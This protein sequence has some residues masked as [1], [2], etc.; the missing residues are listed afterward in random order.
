M[1]SKDNLLFRSEALEAKQDRLHGQI[2]LKQTTSSVL[3]SVVIVSIII[4]AVIWITWGEYARTEQVLGILDTTQPSSKIMAQRSGIITELNVSEGEVVQKDDVIAIVDVDR[5]SENGGTLAE[6]SLLAID[7]RIALAAEQQNIVRDLELSNKAMLRGIVQAANHKI[8]DIQNQIQLQRKIVTSNQSL[9]D[10]IG[11]LVDRGF[12]SQID[13]ERRLQNLLSSQ[14]SLSRL[15]QQLVTQEAE[16]ARA[17]NELSQS[18]LKVSREL[19][20]IGSTVE[21]LSQQRAQI[22]GEKSYTISAPISG[23]VTAF[24][25]AKGKTVRPN[26]ALM[27]IIPEGSD[28]EAIL[29]APT[30][31]VGLIKTDQET[32]LL[33]DAFP[34][35]RFGSF[36]A[37]IV[38]ISRIVIDPR[39][40]DV[41]FQIDEPVYKV[42]AKLEMQSVDAFGEKISLQPGMTLTGNIILERQSFLDWIL[43]PLRAVMNRN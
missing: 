7:N 37:K 32:R 3:M 31:A 22:M 43:T 1:G 38:E 30:R 40:A 27:T 5:K 9:F 10:K 15:E 33:L 4:A 29:Y 13:Y 17:Q 26:V 42:K 16:R 41:P 25:A 35:Q 23:R 36:E 21:S 24:Q 19:S 11:D 20:D 2:V 12:V 6:S 14:Q 18:I 8:G 34:Y 28:L 39:E